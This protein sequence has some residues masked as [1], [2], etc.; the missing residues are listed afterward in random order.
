MTATTPP[1]CL[2][3]WHGRTTTTT[4][5]TTKRGGGGG[6]RS[7]PPLFPIRLYSRQQQWSRG[8]ISI[9]SISSG[10]GEN[11]SGGGKV[12]LLCYPRCKVLG[13]IYGLAWCFSQSSSFPPPSAF[14][15]PSVSAFFGFLGFKE[16]DRNNNIAVRIHR[17]PN[18]AI[19]TRETR[20]DGAGA[21][22]TLIRVATLL[23]KN[24]ARAQTTSA[25]LKTSSPP[26]RFLGRS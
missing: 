7:L 2:S 6:E 8:G 12:L 19:K 10:G 4:T 23:R 16:L 18:L 25:P 17:F 1:F 3:K 22:I 14:S 20:S 11:K 24:R 15:K 21:A 5:T 26:P 13:Q 9:Y